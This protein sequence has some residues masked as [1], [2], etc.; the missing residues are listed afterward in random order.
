VVL[1]SDNQDKTSLVRRLLGQNLEN[2][3]PTEEIDVHQCIVKP[4]GDWEVKKDG[5]YRKY[6]IEIWDVGGNFV[7]YATHQVF[8][9]THAIYVIVSNL[10]K[11]LDAHAGKNC[12]FG[13]HSTNTVKDN[14]SHWVNSIHTFVGTQDGNFP[15]IILVGTQSDGVQYNSSKMFGDITSL[16]YKSYALNHL[17]QNLFTI[18]NI[19]LNRTDISKLRSTVLDLG[20]SQL[21]KEKRGKIRTKWK[22]LANEIKFLN[23]EIKIITLTDLQRQIDKIKDGVG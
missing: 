13:K 16:F 8:F 14:I 19:C 4:N 23:M 15:Q 17:H 2:I 10:K 11:G 3:Q 22:A 12:N 6:G 21:S 20:R 7:N 5:R 1:G 9:S 18:S